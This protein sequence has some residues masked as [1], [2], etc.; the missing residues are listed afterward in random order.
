MEATLAPSLAQL[1]G[2]EVLSKASN[3]DDEQE[4]DEQQESQPQHDVD[5]GHVEATV[6]RS[7]NA[8]AALSGKNYEERLA[9]LVGITILSPGALVQATKPKTDSYSCHL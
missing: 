7:A 1:I 9:D 8:E 3:S 6:A 2:N 5:S 4:D